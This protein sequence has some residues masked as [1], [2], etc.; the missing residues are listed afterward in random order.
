MITSPT[1]TG[2]VTTTTGSFDPALEYR[3]PNAAPIPITSTAPI[4]VHLS[5]GCR[6]DSGVRACGGVPAVIDPVVET[7]CRSTPFTVIVFT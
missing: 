1:A 4:A 7:G 5:R 6:V 2:V 3:Y